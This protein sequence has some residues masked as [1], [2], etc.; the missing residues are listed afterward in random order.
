MPKTRPGTGTDIC[1]IFKAALLGNPAVT[2]PH[3][4]EMPD[5]HDKLVKM[6]RQYAHCTHQHCPVWAI[7]Y[8]DDGSGCPDYEGCGLKSTPPGVQ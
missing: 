5:A 3:L 1:P 4:L 7:R 8:G 2:A 6:M